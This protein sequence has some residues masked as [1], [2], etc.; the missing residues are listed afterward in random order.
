MI[1]SDGVI[2]V[3]EAPNLPKKR[4]IT[5][6]LP[7]APFNQNEKPSLS[8]GKNSLEKEKITFQDLLNI[9]RMRLKALFS[10]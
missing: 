7:K 2:D 4:E 10:L 9:L 6:K 3:F 5:V 1:Y 8:G